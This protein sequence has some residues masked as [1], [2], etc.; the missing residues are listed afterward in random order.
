MRKSKDKKVREFMDEIEMFDS[1][2]F[3]IL[4]KLR[5]M[6]LSRS[7]EIQE[8]I[9]YGG[10]LFFL[11]ED[12]AGLFVRKNHVSFEFGSGAQF[13]DPDGI[14]EGAGKLRRH[15]KLRSLEDI[16][17]KKVRFFVKQALSI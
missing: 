8:K 11:K 4:V 1:E 3:E 7:S 2:K 15:L 9:M 14:L 16:E 13:K 6:V 5:E 12:F 10:I 17:T